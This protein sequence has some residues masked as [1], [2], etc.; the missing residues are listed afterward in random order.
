MSGRAAWAL[1]AAV[2]YG[3]LLTGVGGKIGSSE[4][5]QGLYAVIYFTLGVV[6]LG[7]VARWWI[8]GAPA[9]WRPAMLGLGA[10]AALLEIWLWPGTGGLQPVDRWMLALLGLLAAAILVRLAPERV[11]RAWL[12]RDRRQNP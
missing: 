4:V 1:G 6:L 11:T 9:F 2:V 8:K 12:G 5:L 3:V 7:A 10:F